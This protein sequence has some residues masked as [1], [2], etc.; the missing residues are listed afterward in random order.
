MSPSQILESMYQ[1]KILVKGIWPNGQFKLKI[2]VDLTDLQKMA[3]QCST[4][5]TKSHPI[6]FTQTSCITSE[7][8]HIT[9]I[10]LIL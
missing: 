1:N 10:T 8:I 5:K 9:H 7:Y 3:A 4:I 6:L 2:L